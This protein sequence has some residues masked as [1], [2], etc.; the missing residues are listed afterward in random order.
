ME[1][2]I[3]LKKQGKL[4]NNITRFRQDKRLV[5]TG[6]LHS[7]ALL[8]MLACVVFGIFRYQEDLRPENLQ[9]LAAYLKAA[10]SMTDP[11][12]EYRFEAGLDTVYAPF[13]AGLAVSSGDTY[14]F[15]SGLGDSSYSIQLRYNQ[16]SL[17]TSDQYVLIYDRG[18]TGFCVANSYAEYLN[19]NLSS[20]I[21][22][23]SMNREGA[24]ALIT[25]EEGCR[26]AVSVYD[27]RQEL[28]CKW[29]TTQYYVL[30]A[31]IDPAGEHFAVLGLG[32]QDMTLVTRVLY[33]RIGEEEPAWTVDLGEKQV[34]S[35]THDKSGGLVILCDDGIMRYEEG[36]CT[37]S[38]PFTQSIRLFSAREGGD[39]AVAFDAAQRGSRMTRTLVLGDGLETLWSGQ[40]EGAPR[41]LDCQGTTACLLMNDRL[42]RISWHHDTITTD[43]IAHAGAR[44][45]VVNQAGEAILIYSDRAEKVTADAEESR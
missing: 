43:T 36:Q 13:S 28:L 38:V 33:F 9:R 11:F 20:P 35:M 14:S 44:D 34:Y 40:F 17:R 3:D 15:V 2:R 23:A 4:K 31:S 8:G 39:V 37:R 6:V 41:S 21:L 29:L 12:T 32:Q 26:S 22:T 16:P 7:L 25:D 5:V 42:E 45:L 24:F 10:G 27:D 19:D 30:F 1:E 18:G